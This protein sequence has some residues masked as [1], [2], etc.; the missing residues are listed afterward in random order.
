MGVFFVSIVND[1]TLSISDVTT[2]NVSASKHGFTPKAPNDAT[3]FLD[4]TGAWD[5]CKDSD[6]STSDVTTNDVSTSKHG[7]VPK[8]PNDATKFLDGTGVFSVPVA[9]SG[10]VVLMYAT[11]G[12]FTAA[13]ETEL[14]THNFSASD[15]SV[16]DII[17]VITF[18]NGNNAGSV[19]IRINDGTNTYTSA[20]GT[21]NNDT[22]IFTQWYVVQS[23]LATTSLKCQKITA[24]PSIDLGAGA[25]LDSATMIANWL[26]SAFTLSGR[27]YSNDGAASGYFKVWVYKRK[28]V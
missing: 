20:I 18:V 27:G 8:A 10:S 12:A 7:F 28:A 1:S 4:G 21:A 17:E 6:L 26:S 9:T 22:C 25:R 3:K 16:D 11:S 19:K 5:T 2:N 14:W 13:A 24:S 15:F 23:K